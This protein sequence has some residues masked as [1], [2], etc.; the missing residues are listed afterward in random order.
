MSWS[1][2]VPATAPADFD[3]AVDACEVSPAED[4]LADEPK[5]QLGAAR[6]AAK[7]LGALVG[8]HTED[9]RPKSASLSGHA[10]SEGESGFDSISVSVRESSP[11]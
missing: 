4:G 8:D 7:A 6:E 2:T 3:A 10:C 9:V 5:Q 1:A 11:A